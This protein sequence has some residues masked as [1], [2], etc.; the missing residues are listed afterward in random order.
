MPIEVLQIAAVTTRLLEHS[1]TVHVLL[2]LI[3]PALSF[4]V[5]DH[6]DVSHRT[7]FTN[8]LTPISTEHQQTR[9]WLNQRHQTR[10]TER[11]D[12]RFGDGRQNR[13]N[14]VVVTIRMY[15]SAIGRSVVTVF[16]GIHSSYTRSLIRYKPRLQMYNECVIKYRTRMNMFTRRDDRLSSR[17]VRATRQVKVGYRLC[18]CE[19][20]GIEREL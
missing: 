20:N 2:E 12:V 10:N 14:T 3:L 4:V 7:D 6:P 11:V 15:F 13:W 19:K 5:H 16:S 9:R 18:A 1:R 17:L 8:F